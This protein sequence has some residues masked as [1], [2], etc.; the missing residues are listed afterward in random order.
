MDMI[1]YSQANTEKTL[2]RMETQ[3]LPYVVSDYIVSGD[4]IPEYIILYSIFLLYQDGKFEEAAQLSELAGRFDRAVSL[5]EEGAEFEIENSG[6]LERVAELLEKGNEI[7]V[8]YSCD[9]SR[10][11]Q[12]YEKIAE[13]AYKNQDCFRAGEWYACAGNHLKAM[14]AYLISAVMTD[15]TYFTAG[16]YEKA[17][18]AAI[19]AGY[20]KKA[21]KYYEQGFNESEKFIDI[22]KRIALKTGRQDWIME[23]VGNILSVYSSPHGAIDFAIEAKMPKIAI[24]ICVEHHIYETAAEIAER[25]E[26]VDQAKL[27]RRILAD[28]QNR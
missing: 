16:Y 25:F 20:P 15:S 23:M 6:N 7:A 1:Q 18:D 5:Y 12:L 26:F 17:G 10:L 13:R 3:E 21:M 19:K 28:L 14:N 24:N 4:E 8:Q 11:M 27:Y 22:R 9:T 2:L